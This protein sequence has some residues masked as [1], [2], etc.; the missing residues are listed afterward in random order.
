MTLSHVI[1]LPEK[2]AS[3]LSHFAFVDISCEHVSY[4]NTQADLS[5]LLV[6]GTISY[7]LRP[8]LVSKQHSN[9]SRCFTSGPLLQDPGMAAHLHQAGQHRVHPG[10][11]PVACAQPL[12]GPVSISR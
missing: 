6:S 7:Y 4:K 2:S 10:L 5:A 8:T 9:V 12:G 1:S 3:S 11:C